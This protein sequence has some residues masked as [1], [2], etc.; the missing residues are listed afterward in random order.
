MSKY[1]KLVGTPTARVPGEY[2]AL[3]VAGAF[4]FEVRCWGTASGCQLGAFVPETVACHGSLAR[5]GQWE[6]KP[7][8]CTDLPPCT[9]FG[10]KG[11]GASAAPKRCAMKILLLHTLACWP[12]VSGTRKHSATAPRH[13]T[14]S[15]VIASHVRA[16]V[17]ETAD[18]PVTPGKRIKGLLR[19]QGL[20]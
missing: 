19:T 17:L 15:E 7:S 10:L 16:I 3:C 20:K 12:Q 11:K 13:Q 4:T 9:A 18:M 5:G 1:V 6:H 14:D 2:T 8:R